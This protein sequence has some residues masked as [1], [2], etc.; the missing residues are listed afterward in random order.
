ML[1]HR[2]FWFVVNIGNTSLKPFGRNATNL[3]EALQS[4]HWQHQSHA[5]TD[6]YTS[7]GSGCDLVCV[8]YSTHLLPQRNCHFKHLKN[9]T[10]ING[11]NELFGV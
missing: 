1:K 10:V 2:N 9:A 4:L 5:H 6:V 11:L 7:V 8:R 3:C